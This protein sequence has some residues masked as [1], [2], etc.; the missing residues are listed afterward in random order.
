[1]TMAARADHSFI[2]LIMAGGSGSRFWP[3]SN[4]Q[5]PKQYLKMFGNRSLIQQT[6]D[7]LLTH[8]SNSEIFI[9][10]GESQK[11]LLREQL[12]NI[13]NLILEPVARNTA[14]CLML[15]VREL[16]KQGIS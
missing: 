11:S 12:P 8:Q 2:S 13:T 6:V 10:S 15:S 3:L 4:P 5:T 16:L 1:M 7:R 9:C 14:P